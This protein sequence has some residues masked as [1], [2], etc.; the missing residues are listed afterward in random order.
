M[1]NDN[2]VLDPVELDRCA[3]IVP[4]GLT[5]SLREG[6]RDHAD[7]GACDGEL[8]VL[9]FEAGGVAFRD[10]LAHPTRDRRLGARID[11]GEKQ[12]LV[13]GCRIGAGEP[14]R[15]RK[16]SRTGAATRK[17][18]RRLKPGGRS[19]AAEARWSMRGHFVGS[20]SEI[21]TPQE[22]QPPPSPSPNRRRSGP[23]ASPT[24]APRRWP[25]R[26]RPAPVIRRDRSHPTAPAWRS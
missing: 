10:R 12:R 18:P 19:D 20:P 16:P 13:G 25:H 3:E 14:R 7:R 8:A 11:A 15:E 1:V 4:E 23:G 17:S 5:P 26:N 22:P 24:D 2:E 9:A 21:A 6:G